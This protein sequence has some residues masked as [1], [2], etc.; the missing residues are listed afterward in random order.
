[1][2][3]SHGRGQMVSPTP[4][5][6]VAP[7]RS[8]STAGPTLSP[9]RITRHP[10]AVSDE[11]TMLH[12]V[13]E[14]QCHNRSYP[15]P[16]TGSEPRRKKSSEDPMDVGL[17]SQLA[18][19]ALRV[20]KKYQKENQQLW[21]GYPTA[22]IDG[23][24]EAIFWECEIFNSASL[25]GPAEVLWREKSP[26]TSL[27]ASA[28][29][30]FLYRKCILEHAELRRAFGYVMSRLK[31]IEVKAWLTAGSLLGSIREGGVLVPWDT[32]I[33]ILIRQSDQPQ[34]VEALF[35]G[36]GPDAFGSVLIEKEQDHGFLL[37]AVYSASTI[38]HPMASRVEVWVQREA[39]K[40]QRSS[41]TF[42]LKPC[43]LYDVPCWCPN[44][45]GEVLVAGYGADWC[46]P[47]KAKSS[48]CKNQKDRIA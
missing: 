13:E 9:A 7:A 21:K 37:G 11:F 15:L 44:H 35:H 26:Q 19:Y 38:R 47:C 4:R 22:T 18:T 5:Q 24:E 25:Q 30:R 27:N 2:L 43:L 28:S 10:E 40:M 36:K 8:P 6:T 32:D 17:A 14:I 31:G 45:S 42:P 12:A 34:V 48:S 33:D 16:A 29:L 1:M 20:A 46:L 23:R 39:K 41:I 3:K